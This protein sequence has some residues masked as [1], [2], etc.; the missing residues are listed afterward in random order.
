MMR[1]GAMFNRLNASN[2]FTGKL[3]I[4]K[5]DIHSQNTYQLIEN[6]KHN[7]K[8][9]WTDARRTSSFDRILQTSSS[10]R[11][12]EKKALEQQLV[13]YQRDKPLSSWEL[14]LAG[15]TVYL[16]TINAASN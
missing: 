16:A 8:T 12:A 10:R 11:E 13:I 15:S 4:S 1:N 14:L 2:R 7:I 3:N 5:I 9:Y 6:V